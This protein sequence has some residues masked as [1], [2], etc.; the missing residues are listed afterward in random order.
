[1][2]LDVFFPSASVVFDCTRFTMT[3]GHAE[4][5]F[6]TNRLNIRKWILQQGQ[7]CGAMNHLKR[8]EVSVWR[9]AQANAD[10]NFLG[11]CSFRGVVKR[12]TV[13]LLKQDA[14]KS[15]YKKIFNQFDKDASRRFATKAT[16][17]GGIVVRQVLEFLKDD[18]LIA[19][20]QHVLDLARGASFLKSLPGVQKQDTHTDFDIHGIHPPLGFRRA[21]PF[22]IWIALSESCHLWLQ[23]EEHEFTAG[24]V[25]IFGGDCSHSGA[26]NSSNCDNYRLF[27]YVPTREFEV[28]WAFARCQ[29]NEK[30]AATAIKDEAE[31]AR[32][33]VET[34]P[35]SLKFIPAEYAK[36]LFDRKTCTFYNFTSALWLGG[37]DTSKPCPNPYTRGV[38][39]PLKC[40]PATGCLHCPHFEVEEFVPTTQD[41]RAVLNTFRAQCV[42]CKD[43]KTETKKRLRKD[44]KTETKKRLREMNK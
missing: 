44:R 14:A 7:Y 3:A 30:K 32:L 9:K 16:G 35:L 8:H 27:S 24:D 38:H 26:A 39:L 10:F 1:M 5:G 2:C 17:L 18:V 4:R 43:V 11:F 37:L 33:H 40:T 6:L 41:E 15:T 25:V 23:G 20:P 19:G 42:Y 34:D 36:V 29:Q 31:A 21:K 13:S 22:S 28:P 12:E